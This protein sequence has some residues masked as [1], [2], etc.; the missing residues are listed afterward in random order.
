MTETKGWKFEGS[1]EEF[2]FHDLRPNLSDPIT[3][4]TYEDLDRTLADINSELGIENRDDFYASSSD[5]RSWISFSRYIGP[6]D[7]RVITI[8]GSVFT[9]DDSA[10]ATNIMLRNDAGSLT[11]RRQIAACKTTYTKARVLDQVPDL[12]NGFML[13]VVEAI[14]RQ[15][16]Q[17]LFEKKAIRHHIYY[18]A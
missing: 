18:A 13:H 7:L 14:K 17:H 11:N 1:D 15:A 2:I 12:P 6:D 8:S 4:E 10:A 9:D 3:Q 5:R 16:E